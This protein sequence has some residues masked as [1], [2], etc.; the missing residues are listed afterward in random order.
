MEIKQKMGRRV[1]PSYEDV[2]AWIR[3]GG[4]P[5]VPYPKR[6]E[7][8]LMDSHVYSQLGAMMSARETQ[9]IVNE[10]S[11]DGFGR[12]PPGG[13]NPPGGPPAPPGRPP[14]P[15]GARGAPPGGAPPGPRAPP[16]P[17]DPMDES[18]TTEDM[19]VS[20]TT[21]DEGNPPP[22]DFAAL[23]GS[24]EDYGPAD[25]R[26]KPARIGPAQYTKPRASAILDAAWKRSVAHVAP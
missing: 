19:D 5:P 22:G 8:Q 20:S 4:G 10:Y 12:P 15:R 1:R 14:R 6:T 16:S 18:S 26:S 24:F 7:L 17:G 11:R 13:G 25:R 2:V 23:L 21:E 9:R 3:G